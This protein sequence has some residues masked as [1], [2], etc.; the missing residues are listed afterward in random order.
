MKRKK[1]KKIQIGN[2]P[3]GGDAPISVQSMTCTPTEDVKA[4]VNQILRLEEEGCEI[5]RVAV[6]DKEAADAIDSILKQ[7]HIPLVA[8]IHFNY[9]LA[10]KALEQGVHKIRINPGNIGSPDQIRKVLQAAGERNVP[11][12]IGVNAG[13]LEKELIQ[14]YDGIIAE[15]LVESALKHIRLCEDF[16]FEALVVSI[17]ASHIP[18]MIET[19][20]ML[21][22]KVDYPIHLG[23]TEAGTPRTG[24]LRSA[25][26]IGTLISEGIG[27]TIRVSLTGDPVEE[28]RAGFEILKSLSLR[29]HG[30][31][32]ISCPTCG[33]TH[34]NLVSTVESVEKALADVKTSL[35]VAI[36]GC[37]VNGPG[38]AREADIGVAFGKGSALFFKKGEIVRKLKE[39]EVVETLVKEI[40]QWKE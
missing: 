19:N 34:A 10:L 23:V 38:E 14:K 13:S 28:V 26:G 29:K 27:D 32:I 33:R 1:T 5:V 6:P 3:V 16:G 35:T 30:L 17:K 15:G 18:L 25:V 12:R 22:E 21:S 31:T 39:D 36:M 4:T 11:I 37:V 7:I 9:R 40:R 20:R 2:V 8:D 24:I